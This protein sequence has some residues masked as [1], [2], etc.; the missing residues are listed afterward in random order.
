MTSK[1][2]SL[3]GLWLLCVQPTATVWAQT[4]AEAEV[5]AVIDEFFSAMTARDVERMAS[6]M[7]EDGIIYGYR[8]TP[9][10]LRPHPGF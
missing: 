7:T 2:V 4:D 9:E 3:A 5:L 8:E 1:T 6:L 10:G